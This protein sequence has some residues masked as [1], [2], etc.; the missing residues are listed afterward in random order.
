MA[1]IEIN[2]NPSPRDLRWFGLLFAAFCGVLGVLAWRGSGS[3][4]RAAVALWIAGVAIAVLYYALPHVRRPMYLAW[5]YASYPIGFT[6]SYAV[7]AFVYFA[8]FTPT[9]LVLRLAGRD[10]LARRLD[11]AAKSYWV[12]HRTGG[13]SS[14]YFDQY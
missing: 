12:P 13:A 3:P 9:G 8:V 14:R 11:P 7:L 6:V 2:R 1:L 10:P 4:P 5:V